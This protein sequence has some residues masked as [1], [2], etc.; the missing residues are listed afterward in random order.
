M[1]YKCE[2]TD[3]TAAPTLVV[4]TTAT[5]HT[6]PRTIRDSFTKLG[7]HLQTLGEQPAGPW[8][9]AYHNNDLRRAELEVGVPVSRALPGTD[10]IAPGALPSGRAARTLHR[11]PYHDGC[12][13]WTALEQ[14][15]AAEGLQIAGAS[16]EMYLNDPD[17][18][19]PDALLTRMEIPVR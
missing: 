13:A 19:A 15:I 3:L 17:H 1:S 10:E 14:W 16:Y 9:V 7:R 12:H 5:F 8:Y 18:T 4:R 2:L 6:M 11:G